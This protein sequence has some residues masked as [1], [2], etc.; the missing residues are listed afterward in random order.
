M[1]DEAK[2]KKQLIEELQALR[3][4][5]EDERRQAGEASAVWLAG[6]ADW[7]RQENVLREMGRLLRSCGVAHEG[8]AVLQLFG[9][10][11]F[12]DSAGALFIRGEAGGD[13]EAAV[14]WGPELQSEAVFPREDCWAMRS[15]RTHW[16]DS[17][18]SALRCRHMKENSTVRYLDVPVTDVGDELFLLHIEFNG[19]PVVD[20]RVHELAALV[21]ERAALSVSGLRLRE[22]LKSQAIRDALTG[23]FNRG[24]GEE[25]LSLE[26]HRALR[27]KGSVGLVTVDLDHFE[28]FNHVHGYE[29]GNALLREMGEVIRR[30]VR[31]GDIPCRWEGDTFVIILPDAPLAVATLRAERIRDAVRSLVVVT[32]QKKRP[33]DATTASFGV[34]AFPEHGRTAD[35]LLRMADKAVSQARQKGGDCVAV[36]AVIQQPD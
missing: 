20:R 6:K 32:G 29:E 14:A 25:A 18:P 28:K 12:P 10:R 2:T 26:L 5:L 17:G 23:L 11:L 7:E 21:A 1:K 27:K 34:V 3:R 24:Y 22:K 13:V 4:R 35:E 9:P 16:V 8:L 36:A 30:Q 15:G 33:L 19:D 31:G